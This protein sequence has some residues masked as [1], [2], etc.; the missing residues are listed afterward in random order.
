MTVIETIIV[1]ELVYWM[2]KIF[3]LSLIQGKKISY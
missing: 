3:S 1:I 2:Y